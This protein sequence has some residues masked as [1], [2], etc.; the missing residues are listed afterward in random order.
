M[1][2]ALAVWTTATKWPDLIVAAV[3]AGLFL[4]SSAKILKQAIGELRTGQT[5]PVS[6]TR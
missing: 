4:Y 6:L 1:I 2:A 3:M 5:G